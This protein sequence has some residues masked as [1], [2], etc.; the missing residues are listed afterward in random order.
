MDMDIHFSQSRYLMA[1]RALVMV[2]VFYAILISNITM[3]LMAGLLMLTCLQGFGWSIRQPWIRGFTCDTDNDT[4][5]E[6]HSRQPSMSLKLSNGRWLKAELTHFYCLWWIQVIEFRTAGNRYTLI[7]LPDSC[8]HEDQR[9]I[10][11]FLSAGQ[12]RRKPLRQAKSVKL[13]Q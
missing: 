8:S 12:Y 5:I 11:C 2:G 6:Q 7:I 1:L 4:D 10:R 3:P 9:R 13:S